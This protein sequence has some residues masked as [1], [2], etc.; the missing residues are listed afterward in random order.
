MLDARQQMSALR[1]HPADISSEGVVTLLRRE[2]TT[3][4]WWDV[5]NRLRY[6]RRNQ[7][8]NMRSH[9]LE[10]NNVSNL[11]LIL[12]VDSGTGYC[13]F[14]SWICVSTQNVHSD[15]W[16]C[17]ESYV[18]HMILVCRLRITFTSIKV[19]LIISFFGTTTTPSFPSLKIVSFSQVRVSTLLFPQASR[20]PSLGRIACGTIVQYQ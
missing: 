11:T 16:D 4:A 19:K 8:N 12:Y 1:W 10:L 6:P 5:L 14:P 9:R 20:I 18:I 13:I 2:V 7:C 17:V 15:I 3:S